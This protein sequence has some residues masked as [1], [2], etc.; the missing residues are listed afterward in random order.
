MPTLLKVAG[1][2]LI[3]LGT[4]SGQTPPAPTLRFHHLHYRVPDPGAAL[5]DA[6]DAFQGTRIILQ[7]LGVGVRVGRQYLLFD[8]ME[9]DSSSSRGPK[10]ADAYVEA[11]RW[12]VAKGARVDPPSLADTAVARTIPGATLAHVAFA[13]DDLRT[14]TAAL[15]A[16]PLSANDDRAFF[17]LPSGA[18]VEIVR[19]TDRPDAF[20]CPMHPGVRSPATGT[21]RICAMALVPI[22]PPRLGEYK[23]DVTLVP[24]TGGGASGLQ[25]AVRD[26]E[27]GDPVKQFIDVHDRPFHLF[28]LS[29]DLSQFAHVH[30]E[31]TAD[32]G[33]VLSQDLAAGAHVLIADFLP[34]GG[35]SQLVQR[36][37]VT[38]GYMGP[39]F[40]PVPELAVSEAEQ[41]AG[42]LRIKMEAVSAAPRRET[43]LRF[44][45]SDA[46]TGLPATDLEPYL[47]A[48][49]HLLAVSQDLTA[50]MHAHPEGHV[51]SGPVVTFTTVFPAPGRYKMWAQFQ[52]RGEV[53][54]APFVIEVPQ[55]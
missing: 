47:G 42:G 39:L 30:P 3:A 38:P 26:P 28:I 46:A 54:T 44:R 43:A 9:A 51:T 55:P 36:A 11:V 52:R 16:T 12:L 1:S 19:D 32:G 17:R 15:G 18:T 27:T 34:A 45:I 4:L 14:V 33:F 20:W 49:G 21:C 7:G 29:R 37:V 5:G 48:A 40:G 23:V 22:P 35:T 41:V 8:R 6:A 24:R 31:P 53:V 13:V 50:A 25:I 10:P 2:L